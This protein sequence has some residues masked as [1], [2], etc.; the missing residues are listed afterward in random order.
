MHLKKVN[1]FSSDQRNGFSIQ[2]LNLL[3]KQLQRISFPIELEMQF[4]ILENGSGNCGIAIYTEIFC[5]I[6]QMKGWMPSFHSKVSST[7]FF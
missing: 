5:S 3:M 4:W 6:I 7:A 1:N 2:A